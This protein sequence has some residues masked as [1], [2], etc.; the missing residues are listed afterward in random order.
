MNI[1][2]YHPTVFENF[3]LELQGNVVDILINRSRFF[4]YFWVICGYQIGFP[5]ISGT[6]IKM[7]FAFLRFLV[8]V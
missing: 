4:G 3:E 8:E 2:N 6:N 7:I 5:T 1:I